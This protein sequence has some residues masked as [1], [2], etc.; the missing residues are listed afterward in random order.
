MENTNKLKLLPALILFCLTLCLLTGCGTEARE[1]EPETEL[2][3][4]AEFHKIPLNG[5][6]DLQPLCFT[7]EGFYSAE[8]TAKVIQTRVSLYLSEQG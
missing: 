6:R 3:Y 2:V 4:T 1:T 7:E 8:D 5:D